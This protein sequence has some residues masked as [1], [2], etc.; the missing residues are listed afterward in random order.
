LQITN[1]EPNIP[2]FMTVRAV[3]RAGMGPASDRIPVKIP[4]VLPSGPPGSEHPSASSRDPKT[5]QHLGKCQKLM[6]WY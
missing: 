4:V 2:Y 5:D 3:T 6:L 1:L